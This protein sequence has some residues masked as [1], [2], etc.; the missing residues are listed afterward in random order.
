MIGDD[1]EKVLSRIY[2]SYPALVN[3]RRIR[4]PIQTGLP[5]H[6]ES[7]GGF[8]GVVQYV[9]LILMQHKRS[10]AIKLTPFT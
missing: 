10:I 1:V 6:T 4:R 3:F 9:I 8:P 2:I 7:P 5:G